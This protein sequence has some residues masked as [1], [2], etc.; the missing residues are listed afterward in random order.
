[1]EGREGSHV[2]VLHE[3]CLFEVAF[4]TLIPINLLNPDICLMSSKL[5]FLGQSNLE[6]NIH[7]VPFGFS[8]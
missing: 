4:S 1:M 8:F 3:E 5:L 6:Y 7:F 2:L